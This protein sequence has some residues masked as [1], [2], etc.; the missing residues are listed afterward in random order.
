EAMSARSTSQ[1]WS[2]RKN[3]RV[4][5][6]VISVAKAG[7]GSV[8]SMGE[9]GIV[10][11]PMYMAAAVAMNCKARKNRRPITPIR[12]P[13]TV[14]ETSSTIMASGGIFGSAARRQQ[15]RRQRQGHGDGD[16]KSHV[17]GHARARK[18]RHQH[19]A[20]ADAA[21]GQECQ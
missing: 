8:S 17:H 9:P 19:Q 14:S 16:E 13:M 4:A 10:P 11:S 7:S 18:P 6:S 2:V 12:T 1:C 15:E 5:V 20:A 3:S 21:K